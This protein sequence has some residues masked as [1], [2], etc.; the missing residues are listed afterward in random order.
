MIEARHITKRY[1]E[2]TPVVSDVSFSLSAGKTLGIL[3][4]S[5]SGKTTILK[6]INRMIHPSS[7]EILLRGQD[8]AEADPIDLRRSIG[9]VIQGGGL[10][11]HWTVERNIALVPELLQW[12][13]Q[14]KNEQVRALLELIG[15]DYNTYAGRYPHALSGGEQQRVGI[16]RAL[17]A[18]P[19]IILLD[20]PF[21][22]L[23]PITRMQLQEAFLALKKRIQKTMVFVTHDVREA[24]MLSDKL[25]ILDKGQVQ[26]AG[27]PQDIR[28]D[29]KNQFIRD[30]LKGHLHAE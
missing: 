15:L 19:E 1:K 30:F 17:A 14:R 16:A 7:G 4:S 21:S 10:F 9:Y 11:P 20:E 18:D 13:A 12:N 8:I 23:D 29:P 28:K 6:M 5:G 22:A 24:L 3:G 26:Q 25:I 2:N 27:D